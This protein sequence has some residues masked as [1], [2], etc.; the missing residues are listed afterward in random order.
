MSHLSIEAAFAALDEAVAVLPVVRLPLGQALN[1][2]T[3][4]PPTAQCD[5]PPF[6]QSAMDGYALRAADAPQPQ[7]RLPLSA[8]VAAGPHD[9][10]PVLPAGHACRIY[11]GGLIPQGADAVV[12]Q[13]WTDI[14]C[15]LF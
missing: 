2:V 4:E 1:R 14:V 13:E 11:T 8:T 5:L 7:A 15:T 12:R 9:T 3:A 6:D 10:L